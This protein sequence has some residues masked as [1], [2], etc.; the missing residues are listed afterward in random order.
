MVYLYKSEIR[1]VPQEILGF[2]NF[3][4]RVQT[5]DVPPQNLIDVSTNT[6][7]RGECVL[8]LGGGALHAL[9]TVAGGPDFHPFTHQLRGS[10]FVINLFCLCPTAWLVFIPQGSPMAD[11]SLSILYTA[12]VCVSPNLNI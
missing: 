12:C 11:L 1:R 5:R 6:K 7:T 10:L 3:E 9:T 4:R 8:G 2:Q